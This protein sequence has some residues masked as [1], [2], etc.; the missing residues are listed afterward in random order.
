VTGLVGPGQEVTWEATHLGVRQRLTARITAFDRPRHF[1]DSQI[2]G[3]FARFDHDHFFEDQNGSTVMRDV[4]DFASP[5]GLLGRF[6]D[7][8]FLRAYMR[9]FLIDRAAVIKAVAEELQS[10]STI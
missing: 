1:R 9:R 8:L 4:F 5:L 6:V 3:A 2:R 7:R 10:K